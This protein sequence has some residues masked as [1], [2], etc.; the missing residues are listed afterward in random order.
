MGCT[1]PTR[2]LLVASSTDPDPSSRRGDAMP[3]RGAPAVD[4][5]SPGA[6]VLPSFSAS[7][8]QQRGAAGA[9]DPCERGTMPA[10]RLYTSL[11]SKSCILPSLPTLSSNAAYAA[12]L[13]QADPLA[14]DASGDGT[15]RG[16]PIPEAGSE[17]GGVSRV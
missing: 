9:R 7:E 3:R 4:E 2:E 1:N 13:L 8:V 5:T 11:P 6:A 12:G 14:S 16:R 15:C 17:E 10:Y